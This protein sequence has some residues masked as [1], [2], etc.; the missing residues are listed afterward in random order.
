MR[1]YQPGHTDAKRSP[2]GTL[3]QG[4]LNI[5]N[6]Q[7]SAVWKKTNADERSRVVAKPTITV[8]VSVCRTGTEYH[9]WRITARVCRMR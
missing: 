6:A 5:M 7:A 3:S 1:I 9:D 4:V 2:A 8:Q